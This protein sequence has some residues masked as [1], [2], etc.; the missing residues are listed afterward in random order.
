MDMNITQMDNRTKG[1][2]QSTSEEK[3][4]KS[5][6]TQLSRNDNCPKKIIKSINHWKCTILKTEL[7]HVEAHRR[8]SRFGRKRNVRGARDL[9]MDVGAHPGSPTQPC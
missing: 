7:N 3:N 1:S 6:H 4:Y 2:E 8:E 9:H 5:P